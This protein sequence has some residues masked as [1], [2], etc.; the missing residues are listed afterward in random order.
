MWAFIRSCKVYSVRIWVL[1]AFFWLIWL[2]VKADWMQSWNFTS[3]CRA[4]YWCKWILELLRMRRQ[5]LPCRID[6][7][8]SSL[9]WSLR[10]CHL[11]MLSVFLRGQLSTMQWRILLKHWWKIMSSSHWVLHD[12]PLWLLTFL[13][14]MQRMLGRILCFWRQMSRMLRWD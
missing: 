11:S 8:L 6:D 2:W 13:P 12:W 14:K 3:T 10:R 7:H 4:R 9:M 5:S 1:Y